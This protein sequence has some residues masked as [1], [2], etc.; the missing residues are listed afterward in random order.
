MLAL[1]KYHTSRTLISPLYACWRK[2]I[3]VTDSNGSIQIM[4]SKADGM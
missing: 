4:K 2:G 3:N 1:L